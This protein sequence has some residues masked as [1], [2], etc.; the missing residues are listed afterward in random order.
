[1]AVTVTNTL[2]L[3]AVHSLARNQATVETS[4]KRL[5]TGFRVNTGKDD[6]AG[7]IASEY[8]RSEIASTNAAIANAQR[9]D[10]V[11]ATA[12]GGLSEVSNLLVNLQELVTASANRGALGSDEIDANQ[13][14]VD[15]IIHTIDRLTNGTSFGGRPLLNGGYAY[16]TSAG[17]K[18][19]ALRGLNIFAARVPAAGQIVNVQVLAS[20]QHGVLLAQT[21]GGALASAVTLW[22]GGNNGTTSVSFASGTHTSAVAFSINHYSGATGVVASANANSLAFSTVGYGAAQFVSVQ[23]SAAGFQIQKLG[24]GGAVQ[25]NGVDARVTING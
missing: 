16:Q 13:L 11:L 15:S 4:L 23:S 8:L 7:L 20:A 6:P 9:A 1:M 10:Q 25:S 18:G 14:Q 3:S 5:S 17:S 21:T 24:G 2:A 19:A 12:E 22:I